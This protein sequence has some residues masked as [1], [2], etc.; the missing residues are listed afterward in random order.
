M[1]ANFKI[2][3]TQNIM[4]FTWLLPGYISIY[5]YTYKSQ[6]TGNCILIISVC[7]VKSH[8][9]SPLSLNNLY[10]DIFI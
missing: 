7:T 5:I 8:L 2:L 4:C 10:E 1:I 6:L 3:M 9:I